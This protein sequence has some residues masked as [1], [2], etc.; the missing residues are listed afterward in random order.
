MLLK[1]KTQLTL[2]LSNYFFFCEVVVFINTRL[3]FDSESSLLV[4]V[5][6][7]VINSQTLMCASRKCTNTTEDP[8]IHRLLRIPV[9]KASNA[10]EIKI[11]G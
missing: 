3:L 2:K 9:R 5:R 7:G 1:L 10:S 4:I 6:K 8:T 11:E